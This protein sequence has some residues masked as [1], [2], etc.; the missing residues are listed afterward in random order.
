MRLRFWHKEPP[1]GPDA[2]RA[3]K[4]SGELLRA[5]KD[6]W[7]EVLRQAEWAREARKRNHLTDLFFDFRGGNHD[8]G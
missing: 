7:P 4:E 1:R 6:Q 2:E 3:A 8:A 5:V